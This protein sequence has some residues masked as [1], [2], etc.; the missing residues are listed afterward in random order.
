[1]RI[2]N[3]GKAARSAL[4]G[5]PSLK[6]RSGKAFPSAQLAREL[7]FTDLDGSVPEVLLRS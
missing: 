2:C 1:M 3:D 4:A 7:G 6:A 5:D